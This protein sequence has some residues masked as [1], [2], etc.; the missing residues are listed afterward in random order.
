[1]LVQEVAGVQQ[2]R[3][4]V[5]L[6]VVSLLYFLIWFVSADPIGYAP[7]FW[8]L[9]V[10]LGFKLLRM[11]HEWYHYT[12]VTEP[13]PP[14]G[15]LP[16]FTVDVLTTFCAGEPH[17]MVVETLEAMQAITYP[18]TSYLCDEAD[19]PYLRSVCK[20][21]GVVHVTRQ[22][23][24]NA[25]AG[26]I[27]NALEQATGDLCVVLDPDHV[28]TP[29]FLDHVVPY[30]SN[31]KVGY[32]QVVQ[33]YGNQEDSLVAL[34]AAEQTYHFYGP[35]MMGMNSYNTTQAIG[36]NCTFRRA[37]LDSIGGH[38]A[39]LTEDMHTAMKLHAEG[40]Q[41]VYVPKVLS[42]GLVPSTLGAFYAQQLKWARG[43]FELLFTVYPR[44]FTRF[45]WRQKLHYATLPLYFLSGLITLIDIAVPILSL[46]LSVYPWHISLGAFALHMAPLLGIGLLIRYKAQQWLREPQEAG[47]HLAGGILRVGSWWVYLLGLVYTFLRVRVPYIPTPKEGNT[48]NELRICLPNIVAIVLCAVAVKYAGRLDWSPYSRLMAFL[49]TCNAAILLAAVGMGQHTWISNFVADLKSQPLR[50]LVEASRKL[51]S[52]VALRAQSSGIALAV[53]SLAL[54]GAIDTGYYVKEQTAAFADATWVLSGGDSLHLGTQQAPASLDLPVRLSS[55]SPQ[56]LFEFSRP[57]STPDFVELTMQN[58]LPIAELTVLK[59]QSTVPLLNWP[60]S[61]SAGNWPEIAQELRQLGSPIL[62]R[63]IFPSPSDPATYRRDWHRL[64]E[65]FRAAKVTNVVW[66]WTPPYPDAVRAHYPGKAFVDWVAVPCENKRGYISTATASYSVYRRQ[67][68]AT[69][70]LH[71]KPVLLVVNDVRM[72]KN[73]VAKQVAEQYAEVK[74]VLFNSSARTQ[75][76]PLLSSR[77]EDL[78]ATM[79]HN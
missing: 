63:P 25:K 67:M 19:D 2:M 66:V 52:G 27:N 56:Q 22:V 49:A 21:L 26:N 24:V 14:T 43:A 51:V 76:V 16:L 18:H 37:A 10:S 46:V 4:L 23:K 39:G 47:L 17:A 12:N 7:L 29:D 28:P 11:L 55:V 79:R 61:A 58:K 15:H 32:V 44:L 8:L 73:L 3:I 59:H 72:D 41:A 20:R 45:T 60:T 74:A 6:G 13:V 40:W 69:M 48:R 68:A 71:D 62:L 70:E 54:V 64:V 5:G 36:A 65:Q 9:T 77:K 75:S 53:S 35:L 30:F 33:A 34:G 38:A 31:A 50:G 78:S 42:R 1:M 57:T